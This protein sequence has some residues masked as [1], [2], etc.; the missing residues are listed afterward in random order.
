MGINKAEN[1]RDTT[2][3][4]AG[5]R[6]F[7]SRRVAAGAQGAPTSRAFP[8]RDVWPFSSASLQQY[9]KRFTTRLV[10]GASVRDHQRVGTCVCVC[11]CVFVST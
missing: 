2:W 8:K 7:P 9:V 11:V 10:V 6:E 4:G 5:L 1:N 3:K